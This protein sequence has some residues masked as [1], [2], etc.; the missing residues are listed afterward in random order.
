MNI[1]LIAVDTLR[2]DHLG[3]Y[4]YDR[5][6]SPHIDALAAQGAV[7]RDC[8]STGNCTHPGFT[9]MLT[10]LYP[11]HHQV[12]AHWSSVD[13]RTGTLMLAER[14]KQEGCHTAAIDNLYDHWDRMGQGRL[15]PWFRRGYDVYEYPDNEGKLCD[16]GV[17]ESAVDWLRH[18]VAEPFLLLMHFWGPHAP[19]DPAPEHRLFGPTDDPHDAR[20]KTALYDGEIHQVDQRVGM[21]VD[22]LDATGL[23]DRTAVVLTADHGEI[24]DDVRYA[25]GVPLSFSHVDLCD[26]VLRVPLVLRAP[27]RVPSAIGVDGFVQLTE[28]TPT[29]LD[30]AGVDA[31]DG[32]DGFSLCPAMA[33]PDT[34][35]LRETVHFSE[36]TYQKKR[37]FGRGDWRLLKL[38]ER[39]LTMPTLELYNV[40]HDPHQR[41]NL[42]DDLTGV[43]RRMEDE[44]DEWTDRMLGTELDPLIVQPV[45]RRIPAANAALRGE[46]DQR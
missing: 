46:L 40:R 2:A 15:Y 43:T 20:T 22:A 26:D 25:R 34:A 9:T 31:P 12:V 33:S 17:A 35:E 27:E 7:F 45:S 21:V 18:E 38:M 44:L 6:T 10:G 5:P 24:M 37:G 11:I 13:P 8:F 30:L 42:A 29:I 32:L 19:Y 28:V 39:S 4:G 14:L 23:A 41:V 16:D 36:C 1:V 3:C